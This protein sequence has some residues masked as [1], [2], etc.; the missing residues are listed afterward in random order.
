M[1]KM[2]LMVALISVLNW[3][4]GQNTLAKAQG[5][6]EKKSVEEQA[7]Q[8]II[9]FIAKNKT[10][11]DLWLQVREVFPAE[12]RQALDVFVLLNEDMPLP[13]LQVLPVHQTDGSPSMRLVLDSKD[14]SLSVEMKE[15]E[16]NFIQI[17]GHKLSRQQALSLGGLIQKISENSKNEKIKLSSLKNQIKIKEFAALN[18]QERALFLIQWRR[19]VESADRV[20]KNQ[21]QQSDRFSSFRFE[22]F[23]QF[24]GA[25]AQAA[26]GKATSKFDAKQCLSLLGYVSNLDKSNQCVEVSS[27]LQSDPVFKNI[28]CADAVSAQLCN[29]LLYGLNQNNS[30]SGQCLTADDV[31]QGKSCAQKFPLDPKNPQAEIDKMVMSLKA[32]KLD[33]D[34]LLANDAEK[35]K[36]VQENMRQMV[37]KALSICNEAYD[38]DA[39]KMPSQCK[40]LGDRQTAF[41]NFLMKAKVAAKAEEPSSASQKQ[42]ADKKDDGPKKAP[43]REA[44]GQPT[45][46]KITEC[47]IWCSMKKAATSTWGIVA[48]TVL[49]TYAVCRV[50]K[51]C[52]TK[53]VVQNTTTS[54]TSSTG[55]SFSD[56]Y[57]APVTPT[58]PQYT[59]GVN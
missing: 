17:N 23:K 39:T 55:V 4:V 38:K 40:E 8:E 13:R 45:Y 31:K 29:P 56:L 54:T 20:L 11:A 1:S 41:N 49:S 18:Q 37:A 58:A 5:I 19:L 26:E 28:K 35:L 59:G 57:Q 25:C 14:K 9:S 7:S 50:T 43:V 52:G 27:A 12:D 46:Q 2:K 51:A 47:D 44:S 34:K 32:L 21:R 22:I 53:K 42:V 16:D 6:Q 3:G 15:S 24:L 48:G 33:G 10:I 30:G 36:V